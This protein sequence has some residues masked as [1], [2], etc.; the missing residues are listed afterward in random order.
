MLNPKV[1]FSLMCIGLSYPFSSVA[2]W[3]VVQLEKTV[4]ESLQ[5]FY[6]P[7]MAVG[8]VY[9]GDVLYSRGFGFADL[10][11]KRPVTSDTYFRIA[12]TSKAFTVAALSILV[13]EG[14]LKWN[15][16]VTKH[17]SE[18]AL[19]D[20]YATRHFRV[21]DLLTHNSGLASG[22]GDSMIWPEPGGFSRREV[23][24][25]LRYLTP[26][27]PFAKRYGYSNV[28]YIT[29]GELIEK[30]SGKPFERFVDERVFGALDMQCFAGDVP[31]GIVKKTALPYAHSDERGIYLIPRNAIAEKGI[32]SSA[33]GGMVCNVTHMLKWIQALLNSH[34]S[35]E[36][37]SGV[38]NLPFSQAQLTKTW[39]PQ[40]VLP[41]SDK[42]RE[43]NGSHI[44]AYGMG[45]RI[46]N[47]GEYK[48]ISHTGT[49][50]GFQAFVVLLPE[51]EFGAVI[52]NNGSNS[53]ARGAVMQA[54]TKMFTDRQPHQD[55]VDIYQRYHKELEA[56]YLARNKKPIAKTAMSVALE[57]VLGKYVDPW[58]GVMNIVQSDNPRDTARIAFEKM[59]TLTGLL[60][61]F[62][63]N[64]FVVRW[65][66]QNAAQ[67]ALIIFGVDANEDISHA[68]L[69]PFVERPRSNHPWTDMKFIKK[70]AK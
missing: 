13:D 64:S 26:R 4:K 20:R 15:D 69:V 49:I 7:G 36:V 46:T 6:T 54:I 28:L 27:A 66:N 60:Q 58:F 56:N 42:E 16:L 24:A 44:K 70:T 41:L 59:P 14:K 43:W 34:H 45:W 48:H 22:A 38:D 3:D 10:Q 5:A 37:K 29:A 52:L 8:V 19:Q 40:T 67:D 39:S 1:L 9:K 18:F 32:M 12:S 17:L 62:Q 51:L 50:S 63:N 31:S 2:Q 57:N 30:V 21:Q 65:D 33:A 55:W 53:G 61:P 23:I 25:N 11:N 47:H 68:S 35:G